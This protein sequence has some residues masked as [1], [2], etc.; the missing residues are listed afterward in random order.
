M[1]FDT[2]DLKNDSKDLDEEIGSYSPRLRMAVA[3]D[4]KTL[5]ERDADVVFH[6]DPRNLN[7]CITV[8]D[9]GKDFVLGS[10]KPSWLEIVHYYE[11]QSGGAYIPA[12]EV[13]VAFKYEI[14]D[15]VYST[16]RKRNGIIA[17]RSYI[18]GKTPPGWREYGV[19]LWAEDGSTTY[20]EL[21]EEWLEPENTKVT[22]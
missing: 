20:H 22:D 19:Y 5:A 7:R 11:E 16:Q 8:L 18:E 21:C 12:K 10:N 14:G 1:Q 9:L 6:G 2:D 17:M 4:Y 3:K 15:T 13:Q